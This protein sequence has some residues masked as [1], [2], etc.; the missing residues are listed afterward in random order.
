MTVQIKDKLEILGKEFD[1]LQ[2]DYDDYVWL[3]SL[4]SDMDKFEPKWLC[5]ANWRGYF[6]NFAVE[7]IEGDGDRLVLKDFSI[8]DS[9]EGFVYPAINGVK[10]TAPSK[11]MVCTIRPRTLERVG[12]H[13]ILS[14]MGYHKYEGIDIPIGL[15]GDMLIAWEIDYNRAFADGIEDE[16]FQILYARDVRRLGFESGYLVANEDLTDKVKAIRKAIVDDGQCLYTYLNKDCGYM[17][18]GL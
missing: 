6:S 9:R 14:N 17:V 10:P 15:T 4:L 11:T 2:S 18:E 5:T 8:N 3:E 12:E 16:R 7:N 13:Y 1:I